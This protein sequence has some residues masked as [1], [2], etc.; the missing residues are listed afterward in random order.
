MSADTIMNHSP[1]MGAGADKVA[2]NPTTDPTQ[3]GTGDRTVEGTPGC[4]QLPE[5]K[6]S[7][8]SLKEAHQQG[9]GG[10]LWPAG[11]GGGSGGTRSRHSPLG[12]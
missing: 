9:P 10:R 11:A 6:S 2:V 4:V 7:H 8:F 5:R 1:E 12:G 3:R